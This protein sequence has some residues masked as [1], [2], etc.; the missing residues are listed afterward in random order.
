MSIDPSQTVLKIENYNLAC[1]PFKLAIVGCQLLSAMSSGEL[2]FFQ[3]FR[4]QVASLSL[5]HRP[6]TSP[7]PIKIFCRCVIESIQPLP[8]KETVTVITIGFKPCP[9]DLAR[10]ITDYL[11]LVERFKIR[12]KEFQ[13]TLVQL[14]PENAK[15]I[16][17]NNFAEIVSP[18]R[19][20][21]ALFSITSSKL[22]FLVPTTGRPLEKGEAVKMKLYFQKYQFSVETA[23]EASEAL[24][25]GA[26][27]VLATAAFCP[28]LVDL[29]DAFIIEQRFAARKAVK[30][31]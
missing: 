19:Q 20:K 31:D 4:G 12:F 21:V 16:G 28:E 6:G 11:T 24:P 22:R 10:I 2:A 15:A 23:I 26:Q 17:Y 3:R 1:A 29:I 25:N 7:K 8:G 5:E 9:P 14:T 27:K 13:D 18:D 30:S